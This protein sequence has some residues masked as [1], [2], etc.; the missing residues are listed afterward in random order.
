MLQVSATAATERKILSLKKTKLVISCEWT[1][2]R[3]PVNQ[4][5]V[6]KCG[7]FCA[8]WLYACFCYGFSCAAYCSF[9]AFLPQET[10]YLSTALG[11]WWKVY[12]SCRAVRCGCG[13]GTTLYE[14][15]WR[16]VST[17]F[18]DSR[19]RMSIT[20]MTYI[21]EI[22]LH[23]Q[24]NYVA[25][26]L[27]DVFF[28]FIPMFAQ[29]LHM[30][31]TVVPIHIITHWFLQQLDSSPNLCQFQAN[32]DG[33]LPDLPIKS[34]GFQ[35]GQCLL[36]LVTMT[37]NIGGR[38]QDAVHQYHAMAPVQKTGSCCTAWLFKKDFNGLCLE[39][40][41]IHSNWR[42]LMKISTW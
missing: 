7:C 3:V 20:N 12:S 26:R 42:K 39:S 24:T 40:P 23:F 33:F 35:T 1:P 22:R 41:T 19:C 17:S 38:R 10:V 31:C 34:A 32:A 27:W 2:N 37:Y 18:A 30:Y 28:A 36:H 13:G 5:D 9:C 25:L 14:E 4:F 11:Q 6:D 15:V 29:C 8:R 16:H 21:A